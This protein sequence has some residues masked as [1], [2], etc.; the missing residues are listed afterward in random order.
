MKI[1]IKSSCFEATEVGHKKSNIRH[2]L[3]FMAVHG[4][5]N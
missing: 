3:P 2:T 1:I 4:G 5:G